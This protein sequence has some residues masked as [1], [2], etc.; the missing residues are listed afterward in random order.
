MVLQLQGQ[1][2]GKTLPS[3]SSPSALE[4]KAL[5]HPSRV[6]KAGGDLGCGIIFS[7]PAAGIKPGHLSAPEPGSQTPARIPASLR[8]LRGTARGR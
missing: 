7:G 2:T 3:S 6:E 4:C 8:S 1:K 5:L